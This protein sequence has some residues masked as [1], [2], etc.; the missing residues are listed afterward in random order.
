MDAKQILLE[1]GKITEEYNIKLANLQE[2]M[3]NAGPNVPRNVILKHYN[4]VS[5]ELNK[6]QNEAN[7]LMAAYY[8]LNYN[9]IINSNNHTRSA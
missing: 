6:L 4:E 2:Y 8:T 1:W 3:N 9:K 7:K 5:R